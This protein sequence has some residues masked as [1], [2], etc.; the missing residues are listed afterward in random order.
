MKIRPAHPTDR[1]RVLELVPRL[2]A[3]GTVPLR[4]AQD[5]DDGETRTLNRYFETPSAPAAARLWVAES[6][7]G[8]VEGVVYAERVTD[9]FTQEPHAHLG[10]LMV[11]EAA[12]GTGVARMLVETVEDWARSS[13]FRFLSLNVFAGNDRARSFYE[14]R[15]FRVDTLRYVKTL[16]I[17]GGGN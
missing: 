2:R 1:A 12:E 5:L 14:R 17:A 9:Y 13:G 4:S 16:D 8:L 15:S 3:F 6:A 10:I 11:S 7:A